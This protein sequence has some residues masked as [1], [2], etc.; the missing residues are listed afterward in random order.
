MPGKFS[1]CQQDALTAAKPTRRLGG[2]LPDVVWGA[3]G[4]SAEQICTSLMEITQTQRVALAARVKPA[5]AEAVQ[6]MLPGAVRRAG[7]PDRFYSQSI[8]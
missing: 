3:A 8:E 6:Q 5:V 1:Q 2:G 7:W 4:I